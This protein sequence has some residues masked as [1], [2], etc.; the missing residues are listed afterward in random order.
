MLPVT[1]SLRGVQAL[2]ASV[3]PLPG[4]IGGVLAISSVGVAHVVYGLIL[5]VVYGVIH[6]SQETRRAD[7]AD[8]H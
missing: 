7:G 4:V 6:D 3:L 8:V 5:G 1:M 2:P